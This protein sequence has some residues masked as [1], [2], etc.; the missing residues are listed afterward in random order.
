MGKVFNTTAYV[1]R[2]NI[3]L[4]DITELPEQIKAL[5][6]KGNILRSTEPDSMERRQRCW[7]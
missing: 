5:V 1:F 2:K 7:H 3:I 4:V 6:E